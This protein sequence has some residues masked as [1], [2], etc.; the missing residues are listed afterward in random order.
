MT[1]NKYYFYE[2][3]NDSEGYNDE[4]NAENGETRDEWHRPLIQTR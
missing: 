4:D 2:E 3:S 1:I